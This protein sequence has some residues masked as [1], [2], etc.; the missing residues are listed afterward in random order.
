MIYEA[1]QGCDHTHSLHSALRGIREVM[2]DPRPMTKR[3][4]ARGWH[5][6]ICTRTR[7]ARAKA[8]RRHEELHRWR[9]EHPWLLRWRNLAQWE[10]DWAN[11]TADCETGGT[12]NPRIVS[13]SGVY[14]G[15][16]QF[17]FSTWH[18]AGGS[19]DPI[20]ATGNEQKVRAVYWMRKKGT[21]PWPNCG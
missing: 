5:Y 12:M 8:R 9:A 18:L 20:N 11:S 7:E 19:G 4:G 14:R 17:D 1:P 13:P 6:V 21:S 3:R 2:I 16:M 10:R 15:L